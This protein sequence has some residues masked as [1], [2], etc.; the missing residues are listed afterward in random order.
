MNTATE[1]EV[2]ASIRLNHMRNIAARFLND[3]KAL[4]LERDLTDFLL[5][6]DR[7]HQ[8]EVQRLELIIKAFNL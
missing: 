3:T 6:I 5:N 4:H 2:V 7:H 1:T 8:E